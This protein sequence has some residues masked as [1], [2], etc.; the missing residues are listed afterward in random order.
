LGGRI[1][2]L[3]IS[4]Y[5]TPDF[6]AG[7]FRTQSLLNAFGEKEKIKKVFVC[8]T[9]P[10][11]YGHMS[12]VPR[13]EKR[14]NMTITRFYT[15][16]HNNNFLRQIVAYFF[17]F[18]SVLSYSIY[19]RKNYDFIFATSSRLGTAFL[20]FI[21]SKLTAKPLAIDIRDIFS[22][23]IQSIKFFKGVIGNT[24]QFIF[25]KIESSIIKHA[26]WVNFVS[27]GFFEYPHLDG[28]KNNIHMFTN[29]IDNIFLDNR[30]KTNNSKKNNK[31]RKRITIIYAGNIGLGQGLESIVLPLAIQYKNQI[32]LKLIGDGSSVNLIK[33][34]IIDN[35]LNNID[36][37]D[38]V[39][40]STLIEYYNSC[41][42]FLLQLN[43]IPAF[44]KV[45]PSKLFDYGSFDKPIIAGVKGVAA[46][47][48]KENLPDS[49]IY[50]P[51]DSQAVFSYIDNLFENGM[52]PI[53]NNNFVKKY[54]RDRIMESMVESIIMNFKKHND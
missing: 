19:N 6:C 44:K 40:R 10:Q 33:H 31:V 46:S 1:N 21:I 9:L 22:D 42:L 37:I 39:E 11:R 25:K 48:I 26:S 30:D 32:K 27:P 47:F 18:F 54:S 29:G 41:D 38:P 23:S 35:Q 3:V 28:L 12:G 5:F 15:P 45:L 52:P 34:G 49:F 53:N 14:R 20:S 2:I 51:G 36:L 24:L 13:F 4:F 43:D 7:S 8:T 17:F 50:N 16:E